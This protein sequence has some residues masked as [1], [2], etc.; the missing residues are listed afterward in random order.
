MSETDQDNSH[1]QTKADQK[2]ERIPIVGG[3]KLMDVLIFVFAALAGISGAFL[4]VFSLLGYWQNKETWAIWTFYCVV[5]FTITACFVSWQK[6]VSE[7][8]KVAQNTQDVST[9][10][11]RPWLTVEAVAASP[12]TFNSGPLIVADNNTAQ[13]VVRFIVTNTGQSPANGAIVKAEIIFPKPEGTITDSL[14][15]QRE[16]CR[17]R[18]NRRDQVTIFNKP[19]TVDITFLLSIDKMIAQYAREKRKWAKPV[20]VGCVDYLVD[21][22]SHQTGFIYDILRLGAGGQ[23]QRVIN[24]GENVPIDQILFLKSSFGGDYAN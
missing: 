8:A 16:M 7:R 12:F 20:L 1:S 22:T 9:P 19:E 15:R 4:G 3:K 11:D 23:S 5:I 10:T 13:L 21:G 6:S 2:G 24:I 17:E 18:G 14:K